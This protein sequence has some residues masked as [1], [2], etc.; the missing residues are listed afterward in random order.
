M[1]RKELLAH[2]HE[3]RS[4]RTRVDSALPPMVPRR[5]SYR[6]VISVVLGLVVVAAVLAWLFF[7][8]KG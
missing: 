8:G 4:G 3:V 6:G 5:R 7:G 2:E 1:N